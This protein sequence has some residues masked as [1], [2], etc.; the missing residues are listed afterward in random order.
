M[1]MYGD[2][3]EYAGSRLNGSI[4]TLN[5]VPVLVRRVLPP[6]IGEVSL[7]EDIDETKMVDAGLLDLKPVRLGYCNFRSDA[8]YLMRKPMRRDY[9]QG[10]RYENFLSVGP[11]PH[12]MI[13]HKKLGEVIVNKYPTYAQCLKAVKDGK[14]NSM[15]WCREWAISARKLHHKGREVGTCIDGRYELDSTH[16]H[17]RQALEEQ[18]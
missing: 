3:W 4:V 6:M 9:K 10:L 13:N 8:N 14:V 17:L 5:G 15:A 18:L 16:T 11:S 2:D 12:T 7:L 1:S